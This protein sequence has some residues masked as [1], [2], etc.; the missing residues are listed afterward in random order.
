VEPNRYWIGTVYT[1]HPGRQQL[2]LSGPA[3]S[4]QPA[5]NPEPSAV[6]KSLTG[7]WIGTRLQRAPRQATAAVIRDQQQ[8]GQVSIDWDLAPNPSPAAKSLTDTGLG[9]VYNACTQ[10]ATA[11]VSGTSSK[12]DKSVLIGT[13]PLTRALL[14]KS[15]KD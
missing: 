11:A 13:L 1:V 9:P 7:Y 4:D 12:L 15:L 6:A 2:L 14:L 8:A 5:P 3:A 10:Q